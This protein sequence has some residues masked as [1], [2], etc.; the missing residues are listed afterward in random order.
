MTENEDTEVSAQ[1]SF[2]SDWAMEM[3][4][5][6]SE[7]AGNLRQKDKNRQSTVASE[8]LDGQ[9]RNTRK[10]RQNTVPSD[11]LDG[12]GGSRN[13]IWEV[14]MRKEKEPKIRKPVEVKNWFSDETDYISM[15]SSSEESQE[16]EEK[17]QNINRK[18]RNQVRRRERRLERMEKVASRMKHMVG[19]GPVKE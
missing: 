15:S 5:E 8:R 6:L 16:E 14:Y 7:Q 9:F 4:R 18:K 10:D 12:Q 19:I 17:W 3:E 13:D 1:S 2:H 11:R